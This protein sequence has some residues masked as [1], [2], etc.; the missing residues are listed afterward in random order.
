MSSAKLHSRS[1]LVVQI[2]RLKDF[3]TKSHRMVVTGSNKT[4]HLD[5]LPL[6]EMCRNRKVLEL[7]CGNGWLGY[8][9]DL[10]GA[11][12]Y[13]GLDAD[14]VVANGARLLLRQNECKTEVEQV[15]IS[16]Q[17]LLSK[18]LSKSFDIIF[19]MAV[20]QHIDI[21]K[22]QLLKLIKL[23]ANSTGILCMRLTNEQAWILDELGECFPIIYFS[24]LFPQNRINMKHGSISGHKLA[25]PK[26]NFVV[27][28]TSKA[29]VNSF[30]EL[31]FS[32]RWILCNHELNNPK[33]K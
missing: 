22:K 30:P 7:G 26:Q 3:M 16:D 9:A 5:I 12:E 25:P 29:S 21:E 6:I 17:A 23:I 2:S 20:F 31:K 32:G 15:D 1:G 19:A 27:A 11:K 28:I 13:V 14:K 24:G 8:L 10:H 4:R 18:Y 33:S